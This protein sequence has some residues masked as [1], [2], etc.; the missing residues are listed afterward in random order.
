[1]NKGFILRGMPEK[2]RNIILA[3]AS[4]RRAELLASVLKVFQVCPSNIEEKHM[5]GGSPE[6][7]AMANAMGK[8]QEVSARNPGAIVIGADTLVVLDRHIFGKPSDA[9]D[10]VD[11]LTKLSGKKHRVI[12]GV[13]VVCCEK[14]IGDFATSEVTFKALDSAAIEKYVAEKRPLDKAGAYGIQE[15]MD[16]FVEKLEGDYNNVVGLPTDLVARMVTDMIML[17]S[18]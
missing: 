6:D 11:V 5:A 18:P 12:T 14:S 3:S 10:A 4:P 7:A 16:Y 15:V 13:A 8:A 1:M 17:T 2:T 9:R